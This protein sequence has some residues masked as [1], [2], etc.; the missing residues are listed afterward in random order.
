LGV[1]RHGDWP[2]QFSP[3]IILVLW[4]FNFLHHPSNEG[5]SGRQLM[6]PSSLLLYLPCTCWWDIA[7]ATQLHLFCEIFWLQDHSEVTWTRQKREMVRGNWAS[8]VMGGGTLG[9]RSSGGFDWALFIPETVPWSQC[10]GLG[11]LPLEGT[12]G[13]KV[14]NPILCPCEVIC[15]QLTALLGDPVCKSC[16]WD[17]C[18]W[19]DSQI[20]MKFV[21]GQG[22][23]VQSPHNSLL[24]PGFPLSS[25]GSREGG[26][27]LYALSPQCSAS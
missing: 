18:G 14:L 22:T 2:N 4:L 21:P 23:P 10:R 8:A 13:T 15:S 3:V 24:G 20:L 11:L 19:G 1:D 5:E 6:L 7:Q 27:K 9:A 16:P 17:G 12:G 26:A 25:S